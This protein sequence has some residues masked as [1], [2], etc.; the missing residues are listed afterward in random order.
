LRHL[1]LPDGSDEIVVG[2]SDRARGLRDLLLQL[3]IDDLLLFLA[4]EQLLTGRVDH[5]VAQ[6]RLREVEIEVR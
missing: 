6:K 1:Q 5:E 4:D 3:K 2:V